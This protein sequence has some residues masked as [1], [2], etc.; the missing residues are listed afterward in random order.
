MQLGDVKSTYADINA[1][2]NYT[3]YA[4]KTKLKDGLTKFILWYRDYYS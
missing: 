3:G 1:I 2:I 4:P